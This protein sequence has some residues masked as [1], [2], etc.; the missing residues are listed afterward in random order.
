MTHRDTLIQSMTP[1]LPDCTLTPSG[2]TRIKIVV[3]GLNDPLFMA[4]KPDGMAVEIDEFMG[5]GWG[6]PVDAEKAAFYV[7]RAVKVCKN[8]HYKETNK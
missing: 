7:K 8:K 1:L 4:V 2:A 5:Y 6:G 3:S